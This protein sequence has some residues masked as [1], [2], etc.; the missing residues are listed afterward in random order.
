[1]TKEVLPTL[2]ALFDPIVL[3]KEGTIRWKTAK[4]VNKEDQ[5][6]I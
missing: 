1:M 5:K 4:D 3:T 2:K 6:K